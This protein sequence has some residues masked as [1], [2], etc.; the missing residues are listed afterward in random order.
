MNHSTNRLDF[1]TSSASITPCHGM[2]CYIV[3]LEGNKDIYDALPKP[4]RKS[5]LAILT[6]Q[7][8]PT[9]V[10]SQDMD[11]MLVV[12]WRFAWKGKFSK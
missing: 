4:M 8:L 10:E 3:A 6:T 11:T 7:L 1:L 5:T 9:I 12:L 2:G